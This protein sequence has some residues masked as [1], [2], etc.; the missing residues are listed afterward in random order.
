MKRLV[1]G[2]AMA[3]GA[4]LAVPPADAVCVYLFTPYPVACLTAVE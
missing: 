4:V 2:L 3:A 1:L